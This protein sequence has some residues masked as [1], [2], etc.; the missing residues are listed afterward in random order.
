[1][2]TQHMRTVATCLLTVVT[3]TATITIVRQMIKKL[4]HGENYSSDKFCICKTAYSCSSPSLSLSLSLS[5]SVP[6]FFVCFML[7][8][9]MLFVFSASASHELIWTAHKTTR[10]SMAAPIRVAMSLISASCRSELETTLL[11]F[12]VVRQDQYP[13]AMV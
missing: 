4:E 12:G 10:A 6:S 8:F 5:L 13:S 3:S 2:F 7:L 1:M 11:S 9:C